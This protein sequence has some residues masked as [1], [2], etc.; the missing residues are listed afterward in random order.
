MK[1]QA[2]FETFQNQILG[3]TIAKKKI[4]LAEIQ[5][6]T[7]GVAKYAGLTFKLDKPA[8]T[9]L[10]RILGISKA[11]RAKL[12]KDFGKNF[13]E[14]LIEIMSARTEGHKAE[15]QMLVDVQ[16][17]T[18]LNFVQGTNSMISN[19]GFLKYLSSV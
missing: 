18:I 16:K 13:V 1:T 7:E 15:I 10:M 11:L 9:S 14:K 3:K 4:T 2:Q 5:I 19:K 17:K 8:F 6:V 12:I